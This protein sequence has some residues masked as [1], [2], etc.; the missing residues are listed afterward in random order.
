MLLEDAIYDDILTGYA[1][2]RLLMGLPVKAKIHDYIKNV[3]PTTHSV[4]LTEGLQQ[5]AIGSD[6]DKEAFRG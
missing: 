6:T 1:E 2:H 3:V 5:L 4:H